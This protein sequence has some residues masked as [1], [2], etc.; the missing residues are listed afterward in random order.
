MTAFQT[1]FFEQR[2]HD[3]LIVEYSSETLR[4]G[5]DYEIFSRATADQFLVDGQMH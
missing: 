1:S 4:N 2:H 3:L 5:R